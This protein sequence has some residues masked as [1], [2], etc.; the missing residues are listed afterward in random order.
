M[1]TSISFFG[2]PF[3]L[4][5]ILNTMVSLKYETNNPNDCISTISGDD[6]C[7]A[8]KI[9]KILIVICAVVFITMMIFRKNI[10]KK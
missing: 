8:I 9:F 6:L 5:G 2:I 3:F 1:L 7:F 10:L 4:F